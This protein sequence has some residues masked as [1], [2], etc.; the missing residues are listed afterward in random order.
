MGLG[1]LFHQGIMTITSYILHTHFICYIYVYMYVYLFL[2]VCTHGSTGYLNHPSMNH[3][4][5]CMS[6]KGGA[7]PLAPL[8]HYQLGVTG[9]LPSSCSCGFVVVWNPAVSFVITSP[10]KT[11]KLGGGFIFLISPLFGEDEPILTIIFFKW[12]GKTTN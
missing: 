2:H 10:P 9:S 5:T 3:P 1:P 8:K 12:V 11:N 6:Q 4:T 7:F